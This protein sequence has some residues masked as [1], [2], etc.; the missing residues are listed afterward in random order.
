MTEFPDRYGWLSDLPTFRATPARVVR[1]RLNEFVADATTQ[2]VEAWDRS[3]PWLQQECGKLIAEH[4]PASQYTAILEYSLPRDS[5]RPDVIV[6]ENGIVVVMELKGRADANQAGLDQVHAYARDLRA[7][8]AAC[9]N[10]PVVPVLVPSGAPETPQKIDG[11]WVVGP[12]G[13]HALLRRLASEC[14]ATPLPTEEFSRQDAYC[15]LPSIVQA[16]RDLFHKRELPRIHRARAAT[17]PALSAITEIAHEAARTSTRH[18]VVLT[19]LPGAGKTLVGLQLAHA[20]WLDDLTVTRGSTKPSVPAVYLSGNGPLVQVLQDALSDGGGGG[21]TFVQDIKKYVEYYGRRGRSV[22]PEHLIVFD[23]A[24]RAH[25]AQR[26]AQVHKTSVG[27]SEPEHLIEFSERIPSWSVLVALVGSGQAIHQGEEGGLPLWREALERKGTPGVWTVHAAS[28][29]EGAFL[30]SSVPTRWTPALNLDTEIRFHLT[31]RLHAFVSA[32]LDGGHATAARRVAD[33][34]HS[35]GHRLLVSRS[36]EQAKEYLRE[37]Y[38]E[39]P[40]ARY[41]LIASA[42]DKRLPAFGV[43]ND[44]QTSKRMRVGPW[45]NADPTDSRSCC[46]LDIVATEFQVQ[47]LELDMSLVAWGS[48]LLREDE[49]WSIRLA[50]GTKGVVRDPMAMRRNVYR[51]LLTRGRDGSVVFVPPEADF[52][53]TYEFLVAAGFR[54]FR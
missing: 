3:I 52:D 27:D 50:R 41:G 14:V 48:D 24:Q 21:K 4:G 29:A 47:G 23:E 44:F 42:K 31:P 5:R 9:S 20:G 8:H 30:G 51:V 36:L 28:V 32:L 53:A 17:E 1:L 19:G 43:H 33:E 37:R 16:A 18:L 6:L 34:L 39:A 49:R 7:Y 13:V 38:A 25:D 40:N 15:P 10:R 45:F 11:S 26:V 54:E 2:Q 35:G 12:R 46:Q 22:P